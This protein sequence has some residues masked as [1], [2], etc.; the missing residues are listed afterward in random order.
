MTVTT[1]QE[2]GDPWPVRCVFRDLTCMWAPQ[3]GIV[4]V[5][6]ATAVDDVVAPFREAGFE[7]QH[8]KYAAGRRYKPRSLSSQRQ[9]PSP[10]FAGRLPRRSPAAG[11]PRLALRAVD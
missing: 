3:Q 9:S 1:L 5:R 4:G 6:S 8:P 11:P 10:R 2:E 7:R